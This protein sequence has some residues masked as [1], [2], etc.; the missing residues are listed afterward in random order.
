MSQITSKCFA[1]QSKNPV[2]ENVPSQRLPRVHE[3]VQDSLGKKR[4][5]RV[6]VDLKGRL[7]LSKVSV[8]LWVLEQ[9]CSCY[10]PSPSST[11]AWITM[12]NTPRSRSKFSFK[13]KDRLHKVARR[14]T[15]ELAHAAIMRLLT[16]SSF[17]SLKSILKEGMENCWLTPRL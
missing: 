2:P 4:S 1:V 3:R 8:V 13:E 5:N 12:G 15:G 14:K 9:I 11:T 16:S 17:Q 7:M 6:N 10:L